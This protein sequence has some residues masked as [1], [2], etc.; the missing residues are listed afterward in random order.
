MLRDLITL[1]STGGAKFSL[2]TKKLL[3][4]FAVPTLLQRVEMGTVDQLSLTL[5]NREG[6]IEEMDIAGTLGESDHVV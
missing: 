3:T 6:L 2:K 4:S 1:T 5:T